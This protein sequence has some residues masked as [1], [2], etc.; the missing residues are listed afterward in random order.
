METRDH[1]KNGAKPKSHM[2][3]KIQ[4]IIRMNTLRLFFI[5]SF[6]IAGLNGIAQ[7]TEMLTNE[8]IV[9]MKTKG[10]PSSIIIARIKFAQN[11]FDISTD[12]LIKLMENKIPDDI[13]TAMVDAASDAKRHAVNL[14]PNNPLDM[15]EA[16]IYYFKKTDDKTELIKLVPSVFSQSKSGGAIASAFTYGIAKVKIG[17]TLDGNNSRIQFEEQ[18]PV[19][20]F[21]FDETKDSFS[22]TSNW[23]FSAATSPNE[24]LLVKL[25]IKNNNRQ[26]ETGSANI[27]GSSSGVADENKSKFNFDKISERIYKVSFEEPLSGEFCFMYAGAVPNGFTAINKVYDFGIK[28]SEL[29]SIGSKLNGKKKTSL[30]NFLFK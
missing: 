19:F 11:S 24:F 1:N 21:Y 20:Y 29:D 6:A 8:T 26:V 12:A 2:I 15:H 14:D 18:N 23:W 5:I 17:V 7:Q 16:G 25:N 10:L 28:S 13:V 27:A 9:D 4:N 22:Q 30:D 3:R